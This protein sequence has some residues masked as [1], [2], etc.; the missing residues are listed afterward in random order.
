MVEA[1]LTVVNEAVAKPPD[2]ESA[3]QCTLIITDKRQFCVA[4]INR[5]EVHYP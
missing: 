4:N 3:E 2:D 5:K 1:P